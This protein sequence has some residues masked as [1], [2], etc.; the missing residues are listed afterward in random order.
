MK[1]LESE[2]DHVFLLNMEGIICRVDVNLGITTKIDFS[3]LISKEA[4]EKGDFKF[5][6]FV[7]KE[8]YVAFGG[9]YVPANGDPK[10]FVSIVRRVNVDE[11]EVMD[12]HFF[13]FD[14]TLNMAQNKV[15]TTSIVAN[16]DV[17]TLKDE[18]SQNSKDYLICSQIIGF[19]ERKFEVVI[20]RKGE[21]NRVFLKKCGE[22]HDKQASW[23]KVGFLRKLKSL[24]SKANVDSKGLERFKVLLN[25]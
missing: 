1:Y 22:M 18:D 6:R 5:H 15:N 13:S 12:F 4:K 9:E 14:K 10:A 7:L 23:I 3:A 17:Y 24:L 20:E 25:E 16:M 8:E 21:E 19:D 2:P 11:G